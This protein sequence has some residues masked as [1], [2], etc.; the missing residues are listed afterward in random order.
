M[1]LTDASAGSPEAAYNAGNY[2]EAFKQWKPLAD[3]GDPSAEFGLGTLYG[4][5]LSVA[6]DKKQAISLWRKAAEQGNA[7]AAFYLGSYYL[8]GEGVEKDVSVAATWIRRAADAGQAQA[9]NQ[10]R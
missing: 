8:L 10:F 7:D 2:E 3:L 1:P 4:Q 9:Q 6:Q 5:G